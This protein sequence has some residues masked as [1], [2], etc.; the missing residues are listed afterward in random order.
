[1]QPTRELALLTT[2]FDQSFAVCR[3]FAQMN[4]VAVQDTSDCRGICGQATQI[5]RPQTTLPD[6]FQYDTIEPE[7][8]FPAFPPETDGFWSTLVSHEVRLVEDSL[9]SC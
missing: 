8:V 7:A 6:E 5:M 4:G 9:F 2:G 1:V 3:P